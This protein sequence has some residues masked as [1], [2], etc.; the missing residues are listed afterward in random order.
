MIF[1]EF[2]LEIDVSKDGG[3]ALDVFT[4]RM[5]LVQAILE[6]G[7]GNAILDDEPK[8]WGVFLEVFKWHSL[9]RLRVKGNEFKQTHHF[10]NIILERMDKVAD[11]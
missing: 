10:A 7:K 9:D 11:I 5:M 1:E 4:I 8:T 2:A 3:G 6:P